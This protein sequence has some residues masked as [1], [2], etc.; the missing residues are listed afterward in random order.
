MVR[1][2]VTLVW[3]ALMPAQGRQHISEVDDLMK[4]HIQEVGKLMELQSNE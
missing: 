4:K 1:V 2:I 3:R